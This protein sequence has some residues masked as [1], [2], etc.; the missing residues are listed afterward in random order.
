MPKDIRS[1]DFF[2]ARVTTRRPDLDY[3]TTTEHPYGIGAMTCPTTLLCAECG[4]GNYAMARPERDD[5]G[6]WQCTICG[7]GIDAYDIFPNLEPGESLTHVDYAGLR[8]LAVSVSVDRDSIDTRDP[9]RTAPTTCTE[10]S[11]TVLPTTT[12]NAS[13]CTDCGYV[14]HPSDTAKA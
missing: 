7:H 6:A 4:V 1:H 10:C 12:P 9:R 14:V 11:G 2:V 5:L 8:L 3:T 13:A